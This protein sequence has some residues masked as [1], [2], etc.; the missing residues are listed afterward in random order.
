MGASPSSRARA[1]SPPP[2][3]TPHTHATLHPCPGATCVA[4]G[5]TIMPAGRKPGFRPGRERNPPTARPT[6]ICDSRLGP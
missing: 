1:W 5:S 3:S 2:P 4:R 6:P